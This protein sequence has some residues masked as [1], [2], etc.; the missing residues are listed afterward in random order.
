M[1]TFGDEGEALRAYN[2]WMGKTL[3]ETVHTVRY[4]VV[5]ET[6]KLVTTDENYV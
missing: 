3:K 5:G 1:D 4:E 2:I 6:F